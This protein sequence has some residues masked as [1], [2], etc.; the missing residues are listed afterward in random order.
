MSELQFLTPHQPVH[1]VQ[2]QHGVGVQAHVCE[3]HAIALF[4][5]IAECGEEG[6]SRLSGLTSAAT[7]T[8]RVETKK[9]NF[10]VCDGQ[11]RTTHLEEHEDV[12]AYD[13]QRALRQSTIVRVYDLP[14]RH[15]DLKALDDEL[16]GS[17]RSKASHHKAHRFDATTR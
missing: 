16:I 4:G 7:S 17:L 5:E 1:L 6:G 8:L 10:P 11:A 9:S 12:G 13:A 14:Q 3:G 2:V 15:G